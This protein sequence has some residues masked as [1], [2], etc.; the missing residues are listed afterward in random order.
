MDNPLLRI[1][2][3]GQ[4]IWVDFLSRSVLNSG[5]LKR[6]MLGDGVCGVTSNP[7]IFEKAIMQNKDY[8]EQLHELVSQKAD[9][10]AIYD[11]LTIEDIRRAADLMRPVYDQTNHSDGYVSLEVNPHLAFKTEETVSEARRLWKAVDKPNVMIKIPGL[12]EGIPAVRQLISEG[13]NINITLLFSLGKYKD[14]AEA[15]IAGLRDRIE[16]NLPIDNIASVASFFLSRIDTLTDS[17][18]QNT[19]KSGG[20]LADIAYSL[21]GK[22]AI[23][24]A[25]VAYKMY[26]DLFYSPAF[27]TIEEKGGH[28]QRLLWA[29]TSTK[30]PAYSDVMYVE[31][32]IGPET[33]NTLPLPTIEA[34]R[35]HGNPQSRLETGLDE[36]EQTI[37]SLEKAG[38]NLDNITK[39]LEEEAVRK[40]IE[41]YDKLMKSLEEKLK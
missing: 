8:D 9:K 11:A 15:Y 2:E 14:V 1:K 29:S 26:K 24:S 36:A 10:A 39:Q 7:D 5:E 21:Q 34:Y 6:L 3:Y 22:T 19:V 38:I 17:K 4:S 23:A 31:A 28:K 13:I 33:V 12:A 30:N 35:D 20:A 27:R 41:P 16:K 32:L 18:L 40:F 25:R 37:K